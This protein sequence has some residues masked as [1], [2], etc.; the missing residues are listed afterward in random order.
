MKALLLTMLL[1][2]LGG[3]AGMRLVDA[4]VKTGSVGPAIEAGAR[5]R[6][7]RLPSQVEDAGRTEQLE[8]MAEQALAQVGLVLDEQQ[9]RYSVLLGARMQSFLANA[10]GQ[11]IG[12]NV[13]GPYGSV[14]IGTGNTMGGMFGWGM[15]FPPPTHYS[16]EVSLLLRDLA[17]AMVVYDTRA[18]HTGPWS[19]SA[20]ILPALFRAALQDFPQPPSGVRQVNIEIPR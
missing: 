1:G 17:S 14:M 3:C 20:N 4:Q 18:N 2:L 10:W 8:A 15:R 7:E 6:F 5:Y 12:P 9:A 11:P 19:D 13:G 16:F